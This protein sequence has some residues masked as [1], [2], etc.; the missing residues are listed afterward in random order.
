MFVGMSSETR[1]KPEYTMTLEYADKLR[2]ELA[3]SVGELKRI[4]E[5][6][7]FRT[8]SGRLTKKARILVQGYEA[9]VKALHE[10]LR[11]APAKDMDFDTVWECFRDPFETMLRKYREAK[12]E[13]LGMFEKN[14]TYA[15]EW[16]TN[17]L[18]KSQHK[19]EEALRLL[20]YV[21]A[22]RKEHGST[23]ETLET[24]F[25]AICG[26]N[27]GAISRSLSIG[28]RVYNSTS[29]AANLCRALELEALLEFADAL[30]YL[31]SRGDR[32]IDRVRF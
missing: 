21:E 7:E 32:M 10:Q 3:F 9:N 6:E 5:D 25:N 14:P 27:D 23:R 17:S 20:E 2:E 11:K 4:E 8:P 15:I 24:F 1:R 13:F 19:A 12:E 28:R 18:V 30:G 26:F 29:A 22:I 16:Y 31:I